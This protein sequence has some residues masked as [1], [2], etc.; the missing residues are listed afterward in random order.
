MENIQGPWSS[1]LNHQS[2]IPFDMK[3]TDTLN[4]AHLLWC[5]VILSE[6]NNITTKGGRKG[7][8]VATAII[9]YSAA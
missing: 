7:Q 5:D 3:V 1:C 2:R 6:E 9:R 4:V 8:I